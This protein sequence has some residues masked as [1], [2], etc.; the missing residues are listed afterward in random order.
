MVGRFL[1]L[2]HFV[3]SQ[4][5]YGI[6]IHR[7]E[8]IEPCAWQL[9]KKASF[10]P[11]LEVRKAIE[12]LDSLFSGVEVIGAGFQALV[13]RARHP[14]RTTTAIFKI[15]HEAI[16]NPEAPDAI[17]A[18]R[19]EQHFLNRALWAD[20]IQPVVPVS[21]LFQWKGHTFIAFEDLDQ[22][23]SLRDWLEFFPAA[24]HGNLERNSEKQTIL[25]NICRNLIR[26][27]GVLAKISLVHR[28]LKPDNIL[29]G[30]HGEVRLIDMGL[31]GINGLIPP[32]TKAGSVSG[33]PMY[34]SS[35]QLQ[36][37][38]VRF[39]DDRYA[40][41]LI[42]QEILLRRPLALPQPQWRAT[43]FYR[44]KFWTP[45]YWPDVTHPELAALSILTQSLV[46]TSSADWLTLFDEGVDKP[47][48]VFL[49]WYGKKLGTISPEKIAW[50]I[51]SSSVLL[52]AFPEKLGFSQ[53]LTWSVLSA[54][55]K[56]FSAKRHP[57]LLW[58][59]WHAKVRRAEGS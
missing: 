28:D 31:S 52:D 21:E 55:E 22:F 23:V 50:E 30:P 9:Q 37:R 10:Q 42:L 57:H 7:A 5:S 18:I 48:E 38:I 1:L 12:R 4:A 46:P 26:S 41:R 3:L 16:Q 6:V 51:L 29:I 17:K 15:S 8:T 58:E 59:H 53:S 35:N 44:M 54:I 39:S 49:P 19:Q 13:F 27:L 20:L 25:K 56:S 40:A 11:S 43:G 47:M 32:K 36:G 24:Y 14:L 2:G 33:T 34:M 45:K